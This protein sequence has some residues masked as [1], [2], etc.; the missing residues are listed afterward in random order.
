M[1]NDGGFVI[2]WNAAGVYAQ[3]Y[4]AN[5][6]AVGS[7]IQA[8]NHN[9]WG[10]SA[11]SITALNDGGFV[12]SWEKTNDNQENVVL[13]QIYDANGTAVD[14]EFQVNNTPLSYVTSSQL[15][16]SIAA[17]NDGGFVI[18][19]DDG[20]Y[21][22]GNIYAQI[23][24]ANGNTIKDD[25]QLNTFPAHHDSPNQTVTALNNGGFILS[26]G[27]NYEIYAQMY[28]ASGIAVGSLLKVN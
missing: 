16:P 28:D 12:I 23:Y 21:D 14:T 27:T 8:D 6:N 3:M 1:L 20:I 5:G 19:W 11:P 10:L 17:L 15:N 25:F 18:T 13:A 2:T 9:I 24:D 26:W 22:A 4:D 7:V